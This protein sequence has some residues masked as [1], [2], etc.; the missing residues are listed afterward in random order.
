MIFW[1]VV[2]GYGDRIVWLGD[3]RNLA[4]SPLESFTCF[5]FMGIKRDGH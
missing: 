1:G 2:V 4:G 3:T 5:D